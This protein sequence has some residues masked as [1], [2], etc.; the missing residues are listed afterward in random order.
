MDYEKDWLKLWELYENEL[1]SRN[2]DDYAVNRIQMK[3]L[4]NAYEFI[5]KIVKRDGG[6]ID[7][8]KL[9]PSEENGGVTAYLTLFYLSGEDLMEFSKI[10]QS[11][12]ALS[13]DEPLDNE[14]C[15]SFTIPHVFYKVR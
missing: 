2:D 14:V 6:R 8:Q 4:Y 11:M 12:S 13:I 3:K 1:G 9:V 7:E 15:I 10:A 5:K